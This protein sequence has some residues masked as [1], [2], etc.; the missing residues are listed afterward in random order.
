MTVIKKQ[1]AGKGGE[2]MSV[3]IVDDDVKL[4][5]VIAGYLDENGIVSTCAY[6]YAQALEFLEHSFQCLVIDVMLGDGSGYDLCAE[7]RKRTTVPI[8]FLTSLDQLT[9]VERAYLSGGDDYIKK[10]FELK[11][12]LLRINA[13]VRR[14]EQPKM[15][16]DYDDISVN[17]ALGAVT[18]NNIPIELTK[19]EYAILLKLM[20]NTHTFLSK[21]QLYMAIWKDDKV[22]DFE[23]VQVHISNLR[24]KLEKASGHTIKTKWGVGYKLV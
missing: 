12:L 15:P 7:F 22:Q 21:K 10:P 11:E 16:L 3:L 19:K 23:T 5:D 20:E 4:A 13:V 17:V 14:A 8:I 9:S 2:A 1:Q 6:G 24:Y 18:I